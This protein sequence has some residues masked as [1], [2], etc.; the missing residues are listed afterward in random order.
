VTAELQTLGIFYRCKNEIV[1]EIAAAIAAMIAAIA[2]IHAAFFA[3]L[4]I[5]ICS[6][7]SLS[8]RR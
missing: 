7:F 5:R 3:L 8:A 4:A 1:M 2:A 6:E